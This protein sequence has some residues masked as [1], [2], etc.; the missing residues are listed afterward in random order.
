MTTSDIFQ[1]WMNPIATP[2][3]S[4]TRLC[5]Q[6]AAQFVCDDMSNAVHH[7]KMCTCIFPD[8]MGLDLGTIG[9]WPAAGSAA[10]PA[11]VNIS[12]T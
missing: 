12:H 7:K 2:P 11:A 8:L 5:S 1:L 4:V 9:V 10:G 3:T 6:F